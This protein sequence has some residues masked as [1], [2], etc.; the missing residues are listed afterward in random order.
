MLKEAQAAD[1]PRNRFNMRVKVCDCS[2]VE[3]EQEETVAV[4]WLMDDELRLWEVVSK[5]EQGM[6][7]KR[8]E[9]RDIQV[10]Q[11]QSAPGLVVHIH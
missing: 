6:T 2:Q 11:V 7:S 4:D 3:N 5:D 9:G 8:S 1:W 10:E